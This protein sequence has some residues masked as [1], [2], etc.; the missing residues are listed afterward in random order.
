MRFGVSIALAFALTA[1]GT[2]ALAAGVVILQPGPE[3]ED[4]APYEFLPSSIRGNGE[5]LYAFTDPEGGHDF[6]SFLHFPL[7]PDLLGEGEVV[8]E[9]L[10]SLFYGFEFTI[11]GDTTDVIGAIEC[12]EVLEP[13]SEATLTWLN[14]PAY[15]PPVDVVEDIDEIGAV[16]CD[17]TGLVADWAAGVRPNHGIAVTNPT[18]RLIAFYSF[19]AAVDDV[20]RPALLV[21]TAAPEPE[22]GAAAGAALA[23]LAG[24]AA[25]RARRAAR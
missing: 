2:P 23:A 13:W 16:V 25:R 20:L 5:A 22:A 10:L 12:R 7:P 19:E 3:G 6:E 4:S 11:R 17:V 18:G 1:G 15:G 8:S 14:R 24:L 21:E 9:A